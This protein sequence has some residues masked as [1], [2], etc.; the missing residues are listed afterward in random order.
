VQLDYRIGHLTGQPRMLGG[1]IEKPK[2]A[3]ILADDSVDD[4]LASDTRNTRPGHALA[5]KQ[6]LE[7][8]ERKDVQPVVPGDAVIAENRTLGLVAGLLGN[9]KNQRLL[10]LFAQSIDNGVNA[11]TRLARPASAKNKSNRH[12]NRPVF[13]DNPFVLFYHNRRDFS[14]RRYHRNLTPGKLHNFPFM[15]ARFSGVCI[16]SS[17]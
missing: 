17:P 16:I 3:F 8:V 10:G 11:I 13:C 4:H 6:E 15:L 2:V 9:K 7:A 1:G 14:I 12:T 5:Q